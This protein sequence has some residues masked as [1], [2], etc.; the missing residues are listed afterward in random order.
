MRAAIAAHGSAEEK[1]KPAAL[2]GFFSPDGAGGIR[3]LDRALQPYNGLANRRLQPLGHHSQ[4]ES[5]PG[6]KYT[7]RRSDAVPSRGER[8]RRH[9]AFSLI[10]AALIVG[11][12]ALRLW[13]Y[14]GRSALW[15]D[16]A[17]LASNIV[18]RPLRELLVD[19]ASG[20]PGGASRIPVDRESGRLARSVRVGSRSAPSPCSAP[21][22][23]CFCC[24][25]LRAGSF[26]LGRPARALAICACTTAHPSEHRGKAVLERHRDRDCAVGHRSWISSLAQ[27]RRGASSQQ[28][29]PA[30]SPC[31]FRSPPCSCWPG[32]GGALLV[33]VFA[34][35]IAAH[36]RRGVRRV[37]VGRQCARVDPRRAEPP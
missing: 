9:V 22:Q 21:L 30:R 27:H 34:S 17:A 24:G 12:I 15:T 35:A 5:S 28:W 6:V 14:L 26:P 11:G 25:E 36:R 32:L 20:A 33:D 16:E 3:T 19:A 7:K 37:C 23:R 8:A 10:S 31:G 1:K 2:A 29:R 18:G 4:P 13:Q